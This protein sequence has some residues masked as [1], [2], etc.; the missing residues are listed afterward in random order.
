MICVRRVFLCMIDVDALDLDNGDEIERRY[1]PLF[2]E[3][4]AAAYE[5]AGTVLGIDD[6]FDLNNPFVRVVWDDLATLVRRVADTTKEDIRRLVVQSTEE[7]WQP[8]KLVEELERLEEIAT[9]TRARM[10]GRTETANAYNRGS[11]AGYQTHGVTHVDVLDG[12]E[13][14]PCKSANGQR[15]TIAQAHANPLGHPNCTR[16][17]SPVLPN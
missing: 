3:I 5:D 6:P 10:I 11:L 1:R 9:T 14:E 16:A 17:F 7:G 12:D 2:L 4:L 13:D 15:W 8:S